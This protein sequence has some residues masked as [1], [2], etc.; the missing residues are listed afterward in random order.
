[1]LR[2]RWKFPFAL[3]ALALSWCRLFGLAKI[4]PRLYAVGVLRRLSKTYATNN[5]SRWTR[6]SRTRAGPVGRRRRCSQLRRVL[7]ET[8]SAWANERWVF[9][10]PRALFRI[11]ATSMLSAHFMNLPP[12][13]DGFRLGI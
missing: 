5:G 8:P 9:P 13:L 7:T 3:N 6:A 12:S 4:C 2:Q 11:A 10:M 1:M